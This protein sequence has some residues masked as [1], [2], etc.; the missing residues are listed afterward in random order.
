MIGQNI[1]STLVWQGD[2]P[3]KKNKAGCVWMSSNWKRNRE[4]Q[5]PNTSQHHSA[6]RQV[7]AGAGGQ[8]RSSLSAD[9]ERWEEERMQLGRMTRGPAL[10]TGMSESL[11]EVRVYVLH[12]DAP[13]LASGGQFDPVS[14]KR[15]GELL[16]VVKDSGSDIGRAVRRG[17]ELMRQRR[18]EEDKK[19]V[20]SRRK[21]R[22]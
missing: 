1:P 17:S 16:S 2:S 21:Q 3:T 10:S 6:K 4:E 15:G 19:R 7:G 20:Q 14:M 12:P 18:F 8:Q 13:F 22:L 11:E 5:Q 9:A